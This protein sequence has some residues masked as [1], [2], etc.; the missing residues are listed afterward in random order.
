MKKIRM[1]ASL[2]AA[3]TMFAC[4]PQE[5]TVFTLTSISPATVEFEAE[6]G[7]VKVA[8]TASSDTYECS[9]DS[10]WLT[11]TKNGQELTITAQPNLEPVAREAIV[12][13]TLGDNSRSVTARQKAASKYP[14][15]TETTAIS[16]EY[17]GV[18]TFY[19]IEEQTGGNAIIYMTIDDVKTLS[20]DLYLESLYLS[21]EEVVL[22]VGTY[23]KG[24]DVVAERS[25]IGAA[26]TYIPGGAY[27]VTDEEG[28]E[29]LFSGCIYTDSNK[30]E[31][32]FLV[33]GTITIS[34]IEGGNYLIKTDLTDANNNE[35]KYFYEGVIE[36]DTEYSVYPGATERPDPTAVVSASL[37]YNGINESGTTTFNLMLATEAGCVTNIEFFTQAV[38]YE[39]VSAATFSN[40]EG[41]IT[42]MTGKENNSAAGSITLGSLLDLGGGM[43]FPSGTYIMYSFG[44]Y[45][46]A[47]VASLVLE[48]TEGGKWNI[49]SLIMKGSDMA[50]FMLSDF[51]MSISDG[52]DTEGED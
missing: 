15:Y 18:N 2:I 21:K 37:L 32:I 29:E 13:V 7:Q 46:L 51:E 12:T 4:N 41:A 17:V 44:D 31:N 22:S 27:I 1:F 45:L 49:S 25:Y 43:T 14:G 47:E 5:E 8:V 23:A 10:N 19:A 40:E 30:D 35:Y 20:L 6:G 50:M 9:S 3:M 33:G 39:A 24:E 52:R 26:M 36:L 34:Q 42:F 28:D 11:F 16:A 38:E 48:Q